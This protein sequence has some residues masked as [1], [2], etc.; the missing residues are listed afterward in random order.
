MIPRQHR[1][2]IPHDERGTE[3]VPIAGQIPGVL[4]AEHE[5]RIEVGMIQ[6][7]LRALQSLAHHAPRIQTY[8]PIHWNEPDVRHYFPLGE[9]CSVNIVH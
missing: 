1:D 9:R 2:G 5:E 4:G 8:F 6:R 3:M 7:I